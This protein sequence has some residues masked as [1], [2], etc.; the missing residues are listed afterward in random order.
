[1]TLPLAA[2]KRVD[3]RE[4]GGAPASFRE[5]F[6]AELAYVVRS[7]R[8]LGVH[9]V[10]VEDVAQEVFV[11]VHARFG[12]YDPARPVRPWL[13]SFATRVAANYRRLARH[14][15]EAGDRAPE[16][17]AT[18]SPSPEERAAQSEA[19]ELLLRAL[20]RVPFERRTVVVMHDLD[21][22]ATSVIAESL[23][24]PLNTVYSRLRIGRAEL[25][26]AIR[27]ERGRQR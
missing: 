19:R 13:F 11:L 10:D 23:A 17:H 18:A 8:R 7:L 12:D 6:E 25:E 4:G 2:E 26:E 14:R 3:P 9:E 16:R 24:I 21:G 27:V 20:E 5:V 1:M 22:F 15:R